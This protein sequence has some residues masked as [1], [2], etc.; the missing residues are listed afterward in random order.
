MNLLREGQES[1]LEQHYHSLK[2]SGGESTVSCQNAEIVRLR[3]LL[4]E[5]E[6]ELGKLK[7]NIGNEAEKRSVQSSVSKNTVVTHEIKLKDRGEVQRLKD[8]LERLRLENENWK[9]DRKRK[10]R[11]IYYLEEQLRSLEKLHGEQKEKEKEV[12]KL[13]KQIAKWKAR[14]IAQNHHFNEVEEQLTLKEAELDNLKKAVKKTKT[15]V[16]VTPSPHPNP[17]EKRQDRRDN[18]HS[19]A[20]LKAVSELVNIINIKWVVVRIIA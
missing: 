2:G 14:F 7:M 10:E 17:L 3:K 11:Q 20:R 6:H 18:H 13:T 9:D 8:E 4:D 15:V 12:Q 16:T 19:G 1:A 5:R